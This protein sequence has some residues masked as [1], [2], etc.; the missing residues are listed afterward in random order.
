MIFSN[1]I[2]PAVTGLFFF[3]YFIYFTI[4][5]NSKAPSFKYFIMFLLSFSLFLLGRPLQMILGPEP[6]QLVIVNIRVFIFCSLSITSITTASLFFDRGRNPRWITGIFLAGIALGLVYVMFNTLGT[7]GSYKVFEWGNLVAYD[8]LTPSMMGP[9]YGREV[10][11][12]VQVLIGILLLIASFTRLVTVKGAMTL[13]SYVRN[14]HFL[15]NSGILL[16]AVTFI[17]GS[18]TKQWWLYYFSSMFSSFLF[19]AGV[20]I[21]IKEVHNNYEKLVPFIKEDIIQNVAF[22]QFSKM[23]LIEMLKCLDK[24]PALDTFVI[25]MMKNPAFETKY[26]LEMF[27]S[28]TGLITR[29]L[30]TV[31]GYRNYLIIPLDNQRIGLV[32]NLLKH[33]AYTSDTV[34]ELMDIV[35]QDIRDKSGQETAIGIG[36][37]YGNLEDLRTSYYEALDAQKYAAGVGNGAIVHVNHIQQVPALEHGY[38]QTQKERLLSCIKLSDK[39]ECAK[40]LDEFVQSFRKYLEKR[41]H[42]LKMRLYELAGSIVDAAI[43]GG[44]NER[45]L[46]DFVTGCFREIDHIS[47]YR[48]ACLWLEQ[49]VERVIAQ[50]ARTHKTR[51]SGMMEKA[52]HIIG[53]KYSTKLS[54][55]DV[56]REL[57]ISSSYFLALFKQETGMTF[58]DYLTDVRIVRAK[59]LLVDTSM[60]VTQIA[61]EIGVGN[62]N[63][64]SSMFKKHTGMTAKDYRSSRMKTGT[65]SKL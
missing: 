10:T 39:D 60:S 46:N 44:G 12:T 63:Y 4:I 13:S 1:I 9:F 19:G 31:L 23:K 41:P 28:V 47:D 49:L 37:S 48:T 61:L 64:F 22:S 32:L 21:D 7:I 2:I 52:K 43:T 35:Q 62:P 5:N 34:H 42:I 16:F 11:I 55:K 54:Y 51:T 36:R 59:E 27:G 33:T 50:V 24:D 45:Q 18:V 15:F 40:A 14:K 17:I 20:L 30:D 29:R 58:V 26:E 25:V 56:A 53:K 65:Q 8:A 57:C 6:A 3:I 38:P